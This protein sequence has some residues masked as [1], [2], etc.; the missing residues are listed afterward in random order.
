[1]GYNGRGNKQSR[2]QQQQPSSTT[3]NIK[4]PP[5]TTPT[6]ASSQR[7]YYDSPPLQGQNPLSSSSYANS[8]GPP[9]SNPYQHQ[10]GSNM[11]YYQQQVSGGD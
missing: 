1:M 10:Y 3:P 6:T 5:P 8:L 4:L 7:Y 11:G 9:P 2:H